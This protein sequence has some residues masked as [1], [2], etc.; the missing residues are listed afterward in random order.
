VFCRPG[1]P[2]SGTP[3]NAAAEVAGTGE[4]GVAV[5]ADDGVVVP[6]TVAPASPALGP[7]GSFPRSLPSGSS[8]PGVSGWALDAGALDPCCPGTAPPGAGTGATV[9]DGAGVVGT[10]VVGVGPGI[11]GLTGTQ[12]PPRVTGTWPAGQ[13]SEAAGAAIATIMRMTAHHSDATP[14]T[15]CPVLTTYYATQQ[16]AETAG[17]RLWR[18]H[19]GGGCR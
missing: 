5:E 14:T 7:G 13:G 19:Q 18:K 1:V 9:G 3:E 12:M 6:L 4:L 15:L 11:S 2:A 10:A 17:P 8:F 16:S